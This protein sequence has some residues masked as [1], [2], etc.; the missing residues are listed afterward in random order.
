MKG[1]PVADTGFVAHEQGF[2]AVEPRVGVF[3][4]GPSTVEFRVK[5]GLVVNLPI[6]GAAVAGD[7]DFNVAGG[8]GLAQCVGVEGTISILARR[9]DS[10]LRF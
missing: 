9:V 4:H 5:E 8:E 10:L 3:S 1:E 7:V 6:G 2:K